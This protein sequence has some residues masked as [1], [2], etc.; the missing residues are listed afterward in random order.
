MVGDLEVKAPSQKERKMY[1]NLK[2][3]TDRFD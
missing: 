1:D 2:P 3:W